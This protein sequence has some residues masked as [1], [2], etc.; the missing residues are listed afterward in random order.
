MFRRSGGTQNDGDDTVC[1]FISIVPRLGAKKPAI[2]RSI[3]V[4]PQPE[5][6]SSET[7]SPAEMSSVKSRTAATAPKSRPRPRIAILNIVRHSRAA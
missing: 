2:I 3:V 7:N 1:P 4:L 6:P 5:G